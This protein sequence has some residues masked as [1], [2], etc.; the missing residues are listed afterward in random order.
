MKIK[1]LYLITYED[2]FV[3]S[4]SGAPLFSLSCPYI[5]TNKRSALSRLSFL[6]STCRFPVYPGEFKFDVL[7]VV[8][9]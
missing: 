6:R 9:A 1:N 5:F 4:G 7:V 8:N 3:S 2:C